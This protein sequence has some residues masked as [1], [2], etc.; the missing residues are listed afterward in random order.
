MHLNIKTHS[1]G[2]WK[3]ICYAN[4]SKKK[5]EISVLILDK[6][7]LKVKNTTKDKDQGVN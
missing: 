1:K 3:E 6:L 2:I 4:T 7:G 5:A